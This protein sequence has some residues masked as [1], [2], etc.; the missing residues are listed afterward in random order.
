MFGY[1][2]FSGRHSPFP[3]AG[4]CCAALFI[5]PALCIV[6]EHPSIFQSKLNL[7]PSASSSLK[8]GKCGI[9]EINNLSKN[10]LKSL[11]SNFNVIA[12]TINM[13]SS[14]RRWVVAFGNL[15][16]LIAAADL[17]LRN[18]KSIQVE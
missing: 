12:R 8:L 6:A 14:S 5:E 3:I 7:L 4:A 10:S 16:H 13:T 17:G 2:Y 15:R 11:C 18:S 1:I 9:F